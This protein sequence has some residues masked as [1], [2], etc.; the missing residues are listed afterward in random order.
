MSKSLMA[1]IYGVI[2]RVAPLFAVIAVMAAP[3]ES[4]G[5]RT[6]RG[7]LRSGQRAKAPRVQARQELQA[8]H[9]VQVLTYRFTEPELVTDGE[10]ISDVTL[11]G[12]ELSDTPGAPQLPVLGIRIAVPQGEEVVS[13]TVLPDEGRELATGITVRHAQEP[14]PLSRPDLARRRMPR[15]EEIYSAAATYPAERGQR[16]GLQQQRGVAFEMLQ[17]YPVAYQPQAGR[18]TWHEEIKVELTTKVTAG[19]RGRVIQGLGGGE[20]GFRA[21]YRSHRDGTAAVTLVD[22]PDVI[23]AYQAEPR[24]TRMNLPL[25]EDDADGEGD[26]GEGEGDDPES[27]WTHPTLPCDPATN[28]YHVIITTATLRPAFNGLVT[29]RR[30]QG[31]ASETVTIERIRA[32]YPGSDLPEAIRNFIR[33]AYNNWGTEYILIGGDFNQVPARKLYVSISPEYTD[34]IPSDLYYQCLDGTFNSNGNDRWGEPD[35]GEGGREVDLHAEVQ[36]GRVAA[37]TQT[38]INLWFAKIN[39]YERDREAGSAGYLRSALM[40]GE[41]LGFGGISEYATGMMEQVRNGSAADGYV[42]TGFAPFNIFTKV[43]TLY[44]RPGYEWTQTDISS[45]INGNSYSIINHLGHSSITYNMKLNNADVDGLINTKPVFV[46]SQGCNAGAFDSNCVAEHFTTSTS[47]GAFGGVWNA[48]YGWGA[49][50][51]TDGPSQRYNRYFWDAIFGDGVHTFGEA[52]R[53]SHERNATRVG[54]SYMRW[55]YYQTNLF[56]DPIQQIDGFGGD[57]ELDHPAYR[58]DG[59]AVVSIYLP[60][61]VMR[62][63]SQSVTLALSSDGSGP[64]IAVNLPF[65]GT[66]NRRTVYRSAPVDLTPLGASHNDILYA[67]WEAGGKSDT[68]MIDDEPP[69]IF[70]Y[71]VFSPDD[72]VIRVTWET[73]E[74]ASGLIR[75]GTTVPPSEFESEHENLTKTHSLTVSGVAP[76]RVYYIAI[77]AEDY[78]GNV[79][80]LPPDE[81]ESDRSAYLSLKTREREVR[82]SFDFERGTTGWTINNLSTNLCWEHGTPGYGPKVASRCW[83][84]RLHGRY[85]DDAHAML[86]SPPVQVGKSPVITFRHWFD[87]ETTPAEYR[88]IQ[89]ADCGYV[90]V[91]ADG[92]WYNVG[93]YFSPQMAGGIVSGR[94]SDWQEARL[95]LPAEFANKELRVRFRFVS[96]AVRM[97]PGNPAGWY[98][99]GVT[100]RDYPASDLGLIDLLIDDSAA[101]NGNGAAEPGESFD[102]RLVTFNY[103]GEALAFTQGSFTL[104]VS[105]A[106]A[107]LVALTEGAPATVNYGT[108]AIDSSIT[109]MPYTVS[110]SPLTPPGTVV[111][112]LQTLTDTKGRVYN[113]S[114]AF[115]IM[116]T[117]PITGQVVDATTGAGIADALVTASQSDAS[118]ETMTVDD[119][120]FAFPWTSTNKRY[121]VAVDYHGITTA[122][123]VTAPTNVIINLPIP[124]PE[125]EPD[126]FNF[127]LP[128]MQN[129]LNQKL[130]LRNRAEAS[131]TLS[132]HIY[133]EYMSLA[134]DWIVI[135]DYMALNGTLPPGM[136]AE[137]IFDFM[138]ASF[139]PGIYNARFVIES[140]GGTLYV[141]ITIDVEDLLLLS[142]V[143]YRV[144]DALF[145]DDGNPLG[146]GDGFPEPG[147]TFDV[148]VTVRNDNP[149]SGAFMVG[150]QAEILTPTDGT[151]TF[152]DD[153]DSYGNSMGWGWIGPGSTA[154]SLPPLRMKWDESMSADFVV[155]RAEGAD[156]LDPPRFFEPFEFVITNTSYHQISGKV[157]TASALPMTPPG[158]IS[159]VAGAVVAAEDGEGNRLESELTDTAGNYQLSGLREGIGYWVTVEVAAA[160]PVV[161]PAGQLMSCT[162][163][164]TTN[165]LCTTYGELSAVPCLRFSHVEINDAISGDGDGAVDPGELLHV[166]VWFEN[167]GDLSAM[168]ITGKLETALFEH[169]DCMSVVNGAVTET[170]LILAKDTKPL[171]AAFEV[172]VN[173][174]AKAG[175]YQRFIVT[176][177]TTNDTPQL[178]WAADFKIEVGPLFAISGLVTY[179]DGNISE[180]LRATR[181]AVFD[182]EGEVV[183]TATPT[184]MV[185]GA[186]SIGGLDP[187]NYLVKVVQVPEGYYTVTAPYSFNPLESDQSGIDWLIKP[188]GVTTDPTELNLEVDEGSSATAVFELLNNGDLPADLE[189]E[190]IYNRTFEE[191]KSPAAGGGAECIATPW[192]LLDTSRFNNHELEVSF[193]P[194]SSRE[195]REAWLA[196]NGLEA[197][198]WF[199]RIPAA[200]ARPHGGA[201]LTTLAGTPAAM[202]GAAAEGVVVH[203]QPSVIMT[204]QAMPNK[205]NDELVEQLWGIYNERQT[206]GTLGADS[207]AARAWSATMGSREVVVAVCDTGVMTDHP[208]LAANIWGNPGERGRDAAGNSRADNGI[209]DDG[210][211]FTDDIHGWNFADNTPLVGD[212]HGHGTHV[213]GIIGAVGNNW[214]GVI[215][216]SPN[217]QLMVLRLTDGEG[218]FT[219]SARLAAA[220]EY[221]INNGARI[222]NHSWG[223]PTDSKV[224]Y[225]AMASG[226]AANHLFVIAAGN[227]G[228]NIEAIPAYPAS[229]GRFLAN[230]I[231]V[232]AADHDDRLATFSSW[233]PESVHLAAPGVDILSTVI[234]IM[235]NQADGALAPLDGEEVYDY[236][237]GTSMAAPYVAGAAA[238]LLAH[239]PD[240]PFDVI[241]AA[242]LNGVRKDPALKGWVKSGGHLD[243]AAALELLGDNWLLFAAN[244]GLQLQHSLGAPDSAMIDLSVNQPPTLVAGSYEARIVIRQGDTLRNLPVTLEVNAM[245]LPVLESIEI[246]DDGNRDG[247]A[248]PG[249]QASLRIVLRNNGSAS[250]DDLKAK[251][252]G[253]TVAY[254]Y[255]AGLDV[256]EPT[257]LFEVTF[258]AAPATAAHYTL[259]L[260]DGATPIG[261]LEI[262]IPLVATE[263]LAGVVVDAANQPVADAVV[264]LFGLHGAA[265]TTAADGSFVIGGLPLAGDYNCRVIADGFA[266]WS[267]SLTAPDNAVK[268]TLAAPAVTL[269]E[270]LI[271]VTLQQGVA[272]QLQFSVANAAAVPYAFTTVAAPVQRIG[273]FSDQDGLAGLV[274]PLAELGFEVDYF[275]DNFTIAHEFYPMYNYNEILQK[276]NYTWDDSLLMAYD[277]VI[278]DLSGPAGEGRPVYPD[279]VAAYANYLDRG[280]KLIITGAN[281][282]SR[283]DNHE[284][285]ALLGLESGAASDRVAE[286]A[287]QMTAT[288]ALGAPFVPLAAGDKL[289]VACGLYDSATLNSTTA[290]TALGV[291]SEANKITRYVIGDE[292]VA[293]LWNGNPAGREWAGEG[294]RLDILRSLLWQELV[295]DN[296]VNWL[297]SEPQ[298]GLLQAGS[299]MIT[300]DINSDKSLLPGSYSAAV[301]LLGLAD[302]VETKPVR[303]NLTVVEPLLYAHNLADFPTMVSDW[304]GEPLAGNGGQSSSLIQILWVGPNGQPDPPLADGSPGGDDIALTVIATDAAYGYFGGGEIPANSGRFAVTVDHPFVAGSPGIVLYARAW[305]SSSFASAMAYGDSEL[306]H[307]LT[308]QPGE[309]AFF[310]SWSLTNVVSSF[311]DS[312]GDTIPDRWTIIYRPD[313]DPRAPRLPLE[314]EAQSTPTNY[315]Y[316]GRQSSPSASSEPA[317]LVVSEK[318]LFVLETGLHRIGVYDRVTRENIAYYG[319]KQGSSFVAGSG[320]G[321]FDNPCG[322]AADP[323]PGQHRFAVSDTENHRIQI[324]TYDPDSGAVTFERKFGSQSSTASATA[325]DGTF[326]GP[327]GITFTTAS[328]GQVVVADTGNLRLQ[329]FKL[330]GTW[331]KTIRLGT[332]QDSATRPEGIAFDKRKNVD[333]VWVADSHTEKRRIAFYNLAGSG[334]PVAGTIYTAALT[335]AFHTPTDVKVWSVGVRK[336]LVVVDQHEHRISLLDMDG[337]PLFDFGNAENGEEWEVLTRPYGVA[338]LKD[339]SVIYVAN[340][341]ANKVNWYNLILDGDGDG[342]DDFWEDLNGLDSTRDDADE[343]PDGDGLSNWGEYRAN[344][345]P[346]NPDTDGDGGGD[347]WEMV[348]GDDPLNPNDGP[349]TPAQLI[350]LAAAPQVVEVGESTL[351]IATF[352]DSVDHPAPAATAEVTV[353]LYNSDGALLGTVTLLPD[354]G[355]PTVWSATVNTAGWQPGLIDGRLL[356]AAVDPPLYWEREL[357][358]VVAVPIVPETWVPYPISAFRRNAANPRLFTIY[359]RDDDERG[360]VSYK[361]EHSPSLLP[362]NWQE[363]GLVD[364]LTPFVEATF[365]IDLDTAPW[366][367]PTHNFFRLLRLE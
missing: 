153:D 325:P 86:I 299:A 149:F 16:R 322:M 124:L 61:Q 307:T 155:V 301:V 330:D 340:R 354:G 335:G 220:C 112:I 272:T 107:G 198:Y 151:A 104:Q 195:Q 22:N 212:S 204:Q 165:F 119:G 214:R 349:H 306:R 162:D 240:A 87:I 41:H 76:N 257:E 332:N 308:W 352:T 337:T 169:P 215:G 317:H 277:A 93:A 230:V 225:D 320:D 57:V 234:P 205:P 9:K 45:A 246:V 171:A 82:A 289:E 85:P 211:G 89:D 130:T 79:A 216:V 158:E 125:V 65:V 283:P 12:L 25:A 70:N 172:R 262:E 2:V 38:E 132:Y 71:A 100:F 237:S 148:Y 284:L 123:I 6:A 298:A 362:L 116:N 267:G 131:G 27:T 302:G 300:L 67:I 304:R 248:N 290:A 35:D 188:W 83:G 59:E 28:Y 345:D 269:S 168:S 270:S 29:L 222:S 163:D 280:G 275:S 13:V 180:K 178:L 154:E 218:N 192:S 152:V 261:T 108:L 18:L 166:T 90:E 118:F 150:A 109:S 268:I 226:I 101:G 297:E 115:T 367:D 200:I 319:K 347:L 68:A 56:G 217:V 170:A 346:N 210:N 77:R 142:Y 143:S 181:I 305:D 33:D 8:G 94:S 359:W 260:F 140:N 315:I 271:E 229:Y 221:A 141:P 145:D 144:D 355:D 232:A 43:D 53:I 241:K 256:A 194:D 244:D 156:G 60:A 358:E 334:T 273:L 190:I 173:P 250:I 74:P 323:R 1:K 333:G 274:A 129:E 281:P 193:D 88:T 14:Y 121:R 264:E 223:G 139:P 203:L 314:S 285:A 176:A 167:V 20:G 73:D 324:F 47:K 111:T 310:G 288:K 21:R 254:G 128:Q 339:S 174:D 44:D 338:P 224:L 175:D 366:L 78:V 91:Y 58:S 15:N 19:G 266:R 50:N 126:H 84:T 344:T 177:A 263:T 34:H 239:S 360:T 196:A 303:V 279:E 313:L 329:W 206:G 242:L 157:E 356:A 122:V 331:K 251:L 350:S 110:V 106:A 72:G 120:S 52:N 336:R 326:S 26:D 197:V 182:D 292:G 342:M 40:V 213:A 201:A 186:Y 31:I 159:P 191:V 92:V 114:R 353:R 276:V 136:E 341:G 133:V 208:D 296:Q 103:G 294:V 102:L 199:S 64:T 295:A 42:T 252:D 80:W 63:A 81:H 207:G 62:E 327:C 321:Q 36:I 95:L 249:E 351:I 164:L 343:D 3:A 134:A 233:G 113:N 7:A 185:T 318:F 69:L 55:C 231:T 179:D 23:A 51:S 258:P 293:L 54:N 147:E 253:V 364:E 316:T 202:L 189:L 282:L 236:M 117:A 105:G 243:V 227:S 238:L 209:D 30:K 219:S 357:F 66:E 24:S 75:V 348:N 287:G 48:R 259:E 286:A 255:L 137:I 235:P 183:T 278:I 312:N 311:L 127:L 10:G 39:T 96:D 4:G 146:D 32:A 99:D 97:G 184:D 363:V 160:S 187:T 328:E 37:E 98:I 49:I 228:E 17:L 291:L 161:P 361:I 265:T 365:D 309:S 135:R 245:A 138:L 11:S 5:W 46:Y 247:L